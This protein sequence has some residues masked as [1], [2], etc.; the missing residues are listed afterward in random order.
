MGGTFHVIPSPK[1]LMRFFK[2]TEFGQALMLTDFHFNLT[3]HSA[4]VVRRRLKTH[5]FHMLFYQHHGDPIDRAMRDFQTF[6][7]HPTWGWSEEL[8]GDRPAPIPEARKQSF[9]L[10][11]TWLRQRMQMM[12]R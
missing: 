1:V 9:S 11:M 8:L 6:Y 10:K 7:R 12:K 5:S 2:D 4:F 3:L